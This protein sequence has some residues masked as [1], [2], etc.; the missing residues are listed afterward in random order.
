LNR[1]KNLNNFATFEAY[2]GLVERLYWEGQLIEKHEICFHG[3][4][5]CASEHVSE[6]EMAAVRSEMTVVLLRRV[7]KGGWVLHNGRRQHPNFHQLCKNPIKF[8]TTTQSL[9]FGSQGL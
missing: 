5:A 4:K 2:C 8:K 1:L 7:R 9:E 3:Y 6:P